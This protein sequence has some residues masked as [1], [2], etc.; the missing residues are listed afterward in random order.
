MRK[1]FLVKQQ[2][3]NFSIS[4]DFCTNLQEIMKTLSK[5]IQFSTIE[6]SESLL[7]SPSVVS[8][9]VFFNPPTLCG[10]WGRHMYYVKA[11]A[12]TLCSGDF[13]NGTSPGYKIAN[14]FMQSTFKLAS[15][16]QYLW[17]KRGDSWVSFWL[18]LFK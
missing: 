13:V 17:L 7:V 3:E 1:C 10:T 5:P 14:L 15:V 12:I 8:M 4:V 18:L 16:S 6:G 9:I 11:V 2:W